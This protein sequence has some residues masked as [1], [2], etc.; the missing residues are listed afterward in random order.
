MVSFSSTSY[1][2]RLLHLI[3]WGHWFTFFNIVV[4]IILSLAYLI[5]EP[6]PETTLG[7]LYLF[8]TWISHMGFLTFVGFMLIIFPITLIY[9]KTQVIR[10]ISSVLFTTGLVFL[11]LDAYVY[12][13][14]GYH[15][16]ASSSAQ[17]IELISNLISDNSRLF[18]FVA[19]ITTM[20]LLSIELLVSNY[21]WK[22]LR[23]LQN[24]VFAKFFIFVL[25]LGFFFSHI[26]HIWA[27]ANLEYDILRQDTVL[28]LS[29]PATAKTLLTKYDLFDRED[30]FERKNSPLTFTKLAPKYPEMTQQC[31]MQNKE[32][33]VYIV[34][35]EEMLTEQQI[36][37]FSQRSRKSKAIL[38]HHIDNALPHD[39]LFNMVYGLPTIYKNQIVNTKQLPLLFQAVEAQQFNSYLHVIEDKNTPAQLP[40]WFNGLFKENEIHTDISTFLSNKSFNDHN[41]GLHVY[42][43]KQKDR[44]QFELF[45]DALLLSQKVNN[46]DDI[47][48]ISSIGNQ[49][50]INRFAIKPALFINPEMKSK[51]INYLTSQF[52]VSP[53]LLKNWVNCELDVSSTINGND[54]TSLSSDRIIAN[55][56][57]EGVMVF[58]KDK[59]VFI[60][61][62]SN[63]QS[64]S[65][66]LQSPITVKPDF[67]LLIDGVNFIKRFSQY[68]TND[69]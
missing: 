8:F 65:R 17:I 51:N 30:Y 66:Q 21:A 13:Q 50:P 68:T 16:N 19:L 7:K 67:P 63:F 62:N 54:I 2:K 32:R 22:H 64:Y 60:D 52:D 18:W 47:I 69:E 28:P 39:A 33:S 25:V 12:N 49:L 48:W 38:A 20:A 45:I 59:S 55:T 14:L 42:Y 9:P 35:N 56:I 4:A 31:Q 10:G 61:Q 1:S 3:S 53:T 29:Y 27:D 57:D 24:T 23:D 15:L 37:Q 41:T 5:A 43:F 44:F 26:T 34:L 58:N 40:N 36:A 11:L 46:S 6:L